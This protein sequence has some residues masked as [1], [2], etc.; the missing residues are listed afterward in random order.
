MP[1]FSARFLY[2]WVRA[3]IHPLGTPRLRQFVMVFGF[4]PIASARRETPPSMVIAA[5]RIFMQM[6]VTHSRER[7]THSFAAP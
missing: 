4:S 3:D 6:S 5:S 7:A 2:F 1:S